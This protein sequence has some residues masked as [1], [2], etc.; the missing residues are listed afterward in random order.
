MT[1]VNFSEAGLIISMLLFILGVA[2]MLGL[3]TAGIIALIPKKKPISVTITLSPIELGFLMGM[4]NE[5]MKQD[6]HNIYTMNGI[7]GKF[8]NAKDSFKE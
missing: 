5:R 6:E 7:W 2:V 4:V 1:T 3:V 8:T